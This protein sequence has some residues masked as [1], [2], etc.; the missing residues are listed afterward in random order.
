MPPG[1]R[2]QCQVPPDQE[3]SRA[4]A[5]STARPGRLMWHTPVRSVQDGDAGGGVDRVSVI[6]P[7]SV[8][9][10][11]ALAQIAWLK[12]R[13]MRQWR[14]STGTTYQL[15]HRWQRLAAVK[16]LEARELH[17]AASI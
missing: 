11:R 5:P 12:P 15:N 1:D 4:L 9:F 16:C 13:W 14:R 6:R 3:M 10:R 8:P 2:P 7:R 17:E